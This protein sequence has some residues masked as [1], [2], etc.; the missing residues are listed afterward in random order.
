MQEGGDSDSFLEHS[1]LVLSRKARLLRVVVRE[2]Q[3]P[4]EQMI[5]T[6][7]FADGLLRGC[8]LAWLQKIPPADVNRSGP[9]GL[10][11]AVHV[12]LH[13]EEALRRAKTAEGAVRRR[14][15]GHGLCANAHTRPV[16]RSAGVNRA[17]R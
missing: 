14:I 8:R 4:A 7:F 6:D 9:H 13:G 11:D 1:I 10:G 3:R 17:A 16:I 12:P 5:Q 15:R 2:F